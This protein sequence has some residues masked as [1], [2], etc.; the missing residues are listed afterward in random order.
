MMLK[1]GAINS[2][3]FKQPRSRWQH[4]LAGLA[5]GL[6]PAT[7]GVL[8]LQ[9]AERI[10]FEFGPLDFKVPVKSIEIFAKEGKL[11][12]ELDFYIGRLSPEE[13]KYVR[14][15]LQFR[16]DF[17]QVQVAQFFYSS[18]GEVLLSYVL[19]MT[20]HNWRVIPMLWLL[21]LVK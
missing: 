20:S 13:Q 9:A 8:P 10:N 3:K 16:A 12:P 15:Y 1:K 18:M 11:D 17:S 14:E 21:R 7:I 2:A 5:L 4:W 19:P 6:I